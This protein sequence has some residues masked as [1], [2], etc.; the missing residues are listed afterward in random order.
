MKACLA[1]P[2]QMERVGYKRWLMKII[3]QRTRCQG[4]GWDPAWAVPGLWLLNGTLL[5]LPETSE[6]S[7]LPN[8]L[9]MPQESSFCKQY[10]LLDINTSFQSLK[11]ISA[12]MMFMALGLVI[13]SWILSSKE[14][15]LA[16]GHRHLWLW[17]EPLFKECWGQMEMICPQVGGCH[18]SSKGRRLAGRTPGTQ[19]RTQNNSTISTAACSQPEAMTKEVSQP[20]GNGNQMRAQ[21][22][23]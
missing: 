13:L 11:F 6:V 3:A 10:L 20:E 5:P 19:G 22:Q 18:S 15:G 16:H 12:Q 14:T 4:R 7:L 8:K 21:Y 17:S 9:Q 2:L 1:V 23:K